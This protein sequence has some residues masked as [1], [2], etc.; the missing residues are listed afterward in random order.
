MLRSV[1]A[2]TPEAAVTVVLPD[3]VPLAGLAAIPTVT[4]L[5]ALVIGFARRSR[6]VTS[7]AGAMG[8]PVVESV[9]ST[10]NRSSDGTWLT[11]SEAVFDTPSA[12]AITSVVPFPRAVVK[13]AASMLATAESES[14]QVKLGVAVF[15]KMSL[16]TAV[17]VVSAPTASSVAAAG[18]TSTVATAPGPTSNVCVVSGSRPW[19]EPSS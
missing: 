10:E 11:V 9:G 4:S 13:P 15:P 6:I 3:N 17:N 5:V 8:S 14:S 7:T 19:A 1:N 2:A 18:V 12:V 16:A